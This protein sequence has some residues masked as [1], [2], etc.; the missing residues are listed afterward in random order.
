MERGCGDTFDG[1]RERLEEGW[2]KKK[3]KRRRRRKKEK[4]RKEKKKNCRV[5]SY[6]SYDDTVLYAYSYA[7]PEASIFLWQCQK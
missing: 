6:F 4:K 2:C 5:K 7:N 3:K 1:L